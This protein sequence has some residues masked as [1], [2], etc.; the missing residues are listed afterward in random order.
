MKEFLG[1]GTKEWIGIGGF[2][3]GLVITIAGVASDGYFEGTNN[4]YPSNLL[5]TVNPTPIPSNQLIID[6]EKRYYIYDYMFRGTQFRRELK[7]L[8]EINSPNYQVLQDAYDEQK[9]GHNGKEYLD[10]NAELFDPHKEDFFYVDDPSR[11]KPG[12]ILR[13]GLTVDINPE[14]D[15]L[16]VFDGD[17]VK[18]VG[19]AEDAVGY[20]HE[21]NLEITNKV[22]KVAIIFQNSQIG[23]DFGETGYMPMDF[24]GN[25]Y[26]PNPPS[27]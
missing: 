20:D 26:D 18:I 25:K 27:R 23:P 17:V 1:L 13:Q 22:Y 10:G 5:E 12:V 7:F 3:T 16:A 19:E 4:P 9:R 21:Q 2:G 24:L 14:T 15:R 6:G 11:I 8:K